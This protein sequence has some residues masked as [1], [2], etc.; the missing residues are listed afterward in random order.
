VNEDILKG[1]WTKMR[2]KVKQWWGLLT[3]DDLDRI[4]GDIDELAGTLQERYGYARE[5]AEREI[6]R[7]FASV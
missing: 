4:D 7:R 3:D 2:G 6:E 5:Q 1:K